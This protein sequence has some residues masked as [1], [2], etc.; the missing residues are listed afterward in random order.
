M[1]K[2]VVAVSAVTGSRIRDCSSKSRRDFS[3]IDF[4]ASSCFS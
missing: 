1:N 4:S 2:R 3:V